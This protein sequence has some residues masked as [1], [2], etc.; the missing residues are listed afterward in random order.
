MNGALF[1]IS[2]FFDDHT[3][4]GLDPSSHKMRFRWIGVGIKNYT[5]NDLTLLQNVNAIAFLLVFASFHDNYW[6]IGLRL[7]YAVIY[8]YFLFHIYPSPRGRYG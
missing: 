7:R 8:K 3:V 4:I 2:S 5:C 1:I 6:P